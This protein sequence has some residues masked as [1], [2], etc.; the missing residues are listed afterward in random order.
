[1]D[2]I[3]DFMT[4][5]EMIVVLIVALVAILLCVIIYLFDK[6]SE[7]RKQKQN[8]KELKKLVED[9]DDDIVIKK[10]DIIEEFDLPKVEPEVYHATPI[11]VE[12]DVATIEENKEAE[13]E[14]IQTI[15]PIQEMTL[16]ELKE[17]E[18][19]HEEIKVEEVQEEIK[20]EETIE[21]PVVEVQPV[22][23][24]E[25]K[26]DLEITAKIATIT[27][28]E[29]TYTSNEPSVEDAREE[30]ARITE[31]LEQ[32]ALK[33]DET[34]ETTNQAYEE[35]QEKNAIISMEEFLERTKELEIN[36]QRLEIE[37]ATAPI[38]L[39]EIG[40][41]EVKEVQE[42]ALTEAIAQVTNEPVIM[43]AQEEIKIEDMKQDESITENIE[44]DKKA[45]ETKFKSSPIISPIYGVEN[46]TKDSLQIENTANYDKLD[47]EIKKTNEFLTR[48][49]ELQKKL[50]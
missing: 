1:M 28:N 11:I 24:E 39:A 46:K 48:L 41:T 20:V 23:V 29:V 43:T 49:K 27:D 13:P 14:I 31:M 47:A 8:T 21:E 25:T 18:V 50:D 7:K 16:Q 35:E 22:V 5:T 10:K 17:D 15:S 34:I 9:I 26:P 4:S 44:R 36:K 12:Q 30:I 2:K 19:K 32:E 6:N 33:E 3:I 38:S 37:D 42:S 45:F 40:Q